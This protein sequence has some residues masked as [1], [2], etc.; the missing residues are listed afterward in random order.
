MKHRRKLFMTKAIYCPAQTDQ[1]FVRAMEEHL[2]F[3][4]THCPAYRDILERL[5]FSFAP[6][7]TIEDLS[8]I[9]P[10][11]TSYL[12]NHPLL[13][14]SYEKLLIKTTSS[15]TSGKKTP[16]GFDTS[17]ALNG[18]SMLLHICRYHQLISLKPANYLILG[19]Q[20]SAANKTATA[21]AL[22]WAT[23]S[24]PPKEVVYALTFSQGTY[25]LQKEALTEALI[26]FSRQK[27]PVRIIGFPAYFKWL[28]EE[29]EKRT[30]S[31]PLPRDSKILLGGG[32]KTSPLEEISKEQLCRMAVDLFGISPE[33]FKDH[34]STA[35][36][37]INYISC[38]N[39]HFHIPAYSRVL[40][41]DVQTLAP[42]PYDTPGILNLMTP[43]LS[44]MPYGSILTD[45]LAL[46]REGETCGCGIS[47][48]YFELLG[49]VGM[50]QM[51]TCAQT[52]STFLTPADERSVPL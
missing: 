8:H 51:K 39:H 36:H 1:L 31:L 30:G 32:W 44:S 52:V 14:K 37:P 38:K 17:S 43:L 47:S 21:K 40:I 16:S 34:F 11:P 23:L 46:L 49:R 33:N 25:H 9:P 10:L 3:H 48:P 27:N 22:K 26:R 18:L 41:R 24:A 42:L 4:L 45:D 20:P 12:K 19:Y 35:E 15:G 13:S 2:A 50:P 5:Q 7:K 29:V 28:L 6:L